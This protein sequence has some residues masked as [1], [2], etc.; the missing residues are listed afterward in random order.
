MSKTTIAHDEKGFT[1]LELL[2]STAVFS[3]VLLL[4]ATAVLQVGQIFYKGVVTN[5]IQDTSRKVANDVISAIQY[6]ES[7]LT[8]QQVAIPG[9]FAKCIGTVRYTYLTG[10]SVGSGAGQSL[11]VLWK[12]RVGAVGSCALNPV[13]INSPASGEELLGPNM[14]I[15]NFDVTSLT[16]SLWKVNVTIAYGATDD[17][18]VNNGGVYDYSLCI[19]RNLG[20]QFCAVS[21]I[22][23]Y[24]M[25]RL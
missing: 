13:N 22:T 21:G 14:R 12:D 25:E 6:G 10:K 7:N 11:H 4:C 1:I 17:L 2:I 19:P 16:G 9:G 5:R 23:S 20:G 18:F 15:N 3:V 8:Y 24:A